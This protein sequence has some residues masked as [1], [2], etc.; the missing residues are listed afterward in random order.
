MFAHELKWIESC[1]KF[2][3]VS[4][5]NEECFFSKYKTNEQKI[6]RYFYHFK[7]EVFLQ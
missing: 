7:N 5:Q 3:L 4:A 6:L 1:V 2:L